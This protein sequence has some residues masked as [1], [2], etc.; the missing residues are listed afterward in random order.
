MRLPEPAE[1]DAQHRVRV[2]DGA[3]G[4]AG[5]GTHPFLV[6][7]DRRRQAVEDVDVGPRHRRQKT[8]HERAVGLV[9]HPLRLGRDRAE[10]QRALA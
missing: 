6:D 3:D 4:R 7:E 1:E 2:G 10:D 8:L 5:V 9:D